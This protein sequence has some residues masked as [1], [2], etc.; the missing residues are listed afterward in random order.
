MN[1]QS[2][3]RRTVSPRLCSPEP[4]SWG[5]LLAGSLPLGRGLAGTGRPS[6]RP[7]VGRPCR[8]CRRLCPTV[9]RSPVSSP[10][11]AVDGTSWWPGSE[12]GSVTLG[13]GPGRAAGPLRLGDEGD[14]SARISS[15]PHITSHRRVS[16]ASSGLWHLVALPF[17][18][19][20]DE[21][22]AGAGEG[23]PM[24]C[25]PWPWCPARRG[26]GPQPGSVGHRGLCTWPS[27]PQAPP[28]GILLRWLLTHPLSHARRE[29]ALGKG[30]VELYS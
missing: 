3:V 23:R 10:S 4:L 9:F 2:L 22:P 11:C 29:S 15:G 14:P 28:L 24:L 18:G 6:T 13:C 26:K 8:A 7:A 27:P 20:K 19:F 17:D 30:T 25:L 16:W 21:V 1:P 5:V 12:P